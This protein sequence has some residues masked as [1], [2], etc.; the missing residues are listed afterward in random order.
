M[1]KPRPHFGVTELVNEGSDTVQSYLIK[2]TLAAN[3]ENLILLGG[4]NANGTGNDTY[5]LGRRDGSDTIQENDATP[6]NTD[7]ARVGATITASQLWFAQSGN[8]LEVSVI[9]A[10]DAGAQ[11]FQ[12]VA[13]RVGGVA[14]GHRIHGHGGV[15]GEFRMR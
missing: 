7:I 9:G 11:G 1:N 3:V 2:T 15:A 8:N 14:G 5:V 12:E 6:G 13:A 4:R 10:A